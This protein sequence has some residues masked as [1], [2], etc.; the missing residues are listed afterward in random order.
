MHSYLQ[1]KGNTADIEKR[2]AQ[3]RD[4]IELTNSEYEKDKLSE[5]AAK[6]SNGVAVI[7][8][9]LLHPLPWFVHFNLLQNITSSFI[10]P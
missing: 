8:V 5:R 2:L 9:R 6:L 4:G 3:I 7:K 1:G 10:N